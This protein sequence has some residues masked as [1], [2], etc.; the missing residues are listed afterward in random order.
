MNGF[1]AT[2]LAGSDQAE[3]YGV[4]LNPRLKKA[5]EAELRFPTK[6]AGPISKSDAD[7]PEVIP[8]PTD[9]P[10]DRRKQA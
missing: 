5:L 6:S 10:S 4:D 7:H 3:Q 1:F 9:G 2:M 8:F